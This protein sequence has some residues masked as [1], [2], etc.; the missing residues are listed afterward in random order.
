M[1]RSAMITLI[2]SVATSTAA[3]AQSGGMGKMDMKDMNMQ[4]HQGMKDMGHGESKASM[5]TV[6]H[7]TGIVKSS[8]PEK[9]KVVLA[10][11]P[12]KSLNWPA[13]TMTFSV[14]DK[15]L[16]NKLAA[17]KKVDVAFVQQGSD[18]VITSVK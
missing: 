7:A 17:D 11:G 16:F 6:H 3:I 10:H 2:L 1:K 8:D 5:A 18:Y 9:G 14:N 15:A 4:N 12:V 13:M